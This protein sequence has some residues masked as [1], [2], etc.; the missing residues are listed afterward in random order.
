[1]SSH[2]VHA[3]RRQ[4]R[5]GF[6]RLTTPDE[7]V[8]RQALVLGN[9]PKK[10]G[11]TDRRVVVTQPIT[12]AATV[13]A[14]STGAL[15]VAYDNADIVQNYVA[16]VQQQTGIGVQHDP[17]HGAVALPRPLPLPARLAECDPS[18]RCAPA[19]HY[20]R[21]PSHVDGDGLLAG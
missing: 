2:D 11:A 7:A 5:L 8:T 6:W 15:G 9:A 1:M 18:R 13:T 19:D 10:P 12:V 14:Q 20:R 16:S 21:Q 17:R 3:M 4:L